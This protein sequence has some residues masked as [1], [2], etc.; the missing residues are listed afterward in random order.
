MKK[1]SIFLD[2]EIHRNLKIKAAELGTSMQSI[3]S[4]VLTTIA[5]G[6]KNPPNKKTSEMVRRFQKVWEEGSPG[7]KAAAEADI[8][9]LET[10]ISFVKKSKIAL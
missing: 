7:I 2:E 3:A 1:V 8:V 5:K 10:I 4:E 9:N 6:E